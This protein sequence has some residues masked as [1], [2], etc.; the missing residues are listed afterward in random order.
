MIAPI[1]EVDDLLDHVVADV[2]LPAGRAE[3]AAADERADDAG[4]EIAR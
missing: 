3:D 1:A 4:D 2:E